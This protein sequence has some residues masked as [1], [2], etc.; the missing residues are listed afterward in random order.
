MNRP[1]NT[2]AVRVLRRELPGSVLA[3]S[4]ARQMPHTLFPYKMPP[5]RI[6]RSKEIWLVCRSTDEARVQR[7]GHRGGRQKE[8]RVRLF[9][10]VVAS[11]KT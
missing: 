5:K 2:K 7:T 4:P 10:N 8:Q 1:L 6:F 9:L 11:L 3:S